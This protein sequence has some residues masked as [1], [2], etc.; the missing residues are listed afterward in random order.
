MGC[1]NL[2]NDKIFAEVRATAV[3]AIL[4]RK[5]FGLKNYGYGALQ[6]VGL[7]TVSKKSFYKNN[8]T[9]LLRATTKKQELL[10]NLFQ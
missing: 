7:T 9:S 8:W 5:V 3:Q 4:K 2:Q 10:N 6:Q 1:Q